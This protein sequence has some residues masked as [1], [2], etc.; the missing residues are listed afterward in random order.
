MCPR[1]VKPRT[2]SDSVDSGG[3]APSGEGR[4]LA[5]KLDD[6]WLRFQT[7]LAIRRGRVETVIP[8]TGYGTTSWVRV[9]ARVVRS[10]QRDTGG[11]ARAGALKPLKD[12]MRGWRNFT[13][14][15]VAHARVH[16]TI[17]G[18][19]HDLEADR[20]G[21]VDAR[22][23]VALDAG[24]H[25]ITV[26]S[27]ISRIVEAPVQIVADD[28]DFG[29][30]SDIDDTVMVTALPR[31]FLAAWNTF[32]LDEHAR[33]PTPGMAVLYE[34]IVRT[35]PSAPVVY[36]STGPWNVAPTLSRFLSRNLYPA[37][38]KLLTDWG[39]TPDRW[40]RSGQEHKR[41]SLERL[42]EE[43]PG[44]R[45]LLIGDDGQ[46]D[47]AIY[48]EFAQRHPRNV[49]AIAIRQLSVGE[50]VLAGGRSKSGGQPTPGIPWIY[51]PDGAGMSAQLEQ[52]GIIRSSLRSAD[53]LEESG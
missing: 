10:E 47:E 21:V 1:P 27:G 13:S 17:A 4:H 35:A 37:G 5:L 51:S 33:T 40:F 24:W 18:T 34:R 45:W 48:A 42:A 20:G 44:V 31:P 52:L 53:V 30:V 3:P 38:P 29:V 19:V 15:P 36:L 26:Q 43:L 46:H 50:A 7:R 39:P 32:V 11:G 22:I 2:Q 8:Y 28:T 25:T 9:L 41:T 12:G 49:K 23:P 6:A 14:A 16:V